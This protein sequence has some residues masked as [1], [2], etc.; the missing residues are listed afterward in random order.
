M[1]WLADS[2]SRHRWNPKTGIWEKA[3]DVPE[4]YIPKEATLTDT[5]PGME[6]GGLFHNVYRLVHWW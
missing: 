1:K 5:H 3:A 2:S 4:Q 6:T